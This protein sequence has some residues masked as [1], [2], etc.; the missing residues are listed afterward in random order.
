MLGAVRADGA[1]EEAIY[2]EVRRCELSSATRRP[3]DFNQGGLKESQGV[4]HFA[5][6]KIRE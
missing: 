3:L 4:S 2:G 1:R 5:Q 6:T